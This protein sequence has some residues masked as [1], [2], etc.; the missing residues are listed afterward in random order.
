MNS[1]NA[2]YYA[3]QDLLS[4]ILFETIIKLKTHTTVFPGVLCSNTKSNLTSGAEY[5]NQV[6]Q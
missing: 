1:E 2:Y 6:E 3:T 5:T 4:R